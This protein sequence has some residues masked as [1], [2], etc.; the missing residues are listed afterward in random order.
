VWSREAAAAALP[1]PTLLG[2]GSGGLARSG[3]VAV[4]HMAAAVPPTVGAAGPGRSAQGGRSW[5]AHVGAVTGRSPGRWRRCGD[6]RGWG[7]RRRGDRGGDG[8]DTGTAGWG[9]E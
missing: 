3:A 8:K 7:W 9:I 4:G 1:G 6:G 2:S 5:S